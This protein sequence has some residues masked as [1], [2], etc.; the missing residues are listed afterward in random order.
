MIDFGQPA[1]IVAPLLLGAT[2]SHAGVTIRI[3][4]VEAYLGASDPASHTYRGMTRRN[5]A[6]FG[7]PARLYVYRSYGIHLAGNIVCAPEGVG[8]ACLLRAGEVIDGIP[9]ALQ[10]RGQMPFHRLAQGPGNVGAALGL[11]LELNKESIYGPLVQ[12]TERSAVPE[13]VRGTRIGISKNTEAKL[14]FWIPN[15]ASVSARKGYPP[16]PDQHGE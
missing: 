14:R 7:P 16:Q 13:I 9:L 10:R 5:I 15:H 3:T 12:F 8:H 4:E 1:N 2:I 6:M 11:S